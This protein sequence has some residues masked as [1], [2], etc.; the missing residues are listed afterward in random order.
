MAESYNTNIFTN[1]DKYSVVNG[2]YSYKG[3]LLASKISQKNGRSYKLIDAI[4]IDWNGAWVE[5]LSTYINNT[6][7][8]IYVLNAI[9]SN[10][11]IDDV[12]RMLD[13][14]RASL[15]EVQLSYVTYSYLS[16]ALSAYQTRLNAG[17]YI[18]IDSNN[19]ISTYD[20]VSTSLLN[21]TLMNYLSKAEF[22]QQIANYYT[23]AETDHKIQTEIEAAVDKI[24]DDADE[25]FD[26]LREVSDWILEQDK[27][28]PVT[29]DQVLEIQAKALMGEEHPDLYYKDPAKGTYKKVTDYNTIDTTGATIYYLRESMLDNVADIKERLS[30]LET[31]VGDKTTDNAGFVTYTGM[32]QQIE[33]LRLADIDIY[34]LAR[35][36]DNTANTALAIGTSAYTIANEAYVIAEES[37]A[38]G[39][40]GLTLAIDVDERVGM[41]SVPAH[42]AAM[43]P[44]AVKAEI[45]K[46]LT[47]GHTDT[48]LYIKRT[49][50]SGASYVEYYEPYNIISDTIIQG[51]GTLK[52]DDEKLA[53]IESGAFVLYEHKDDVIGTGLTKR[54][55]DVEERC[56]D[57]EE[58]IEEN[59]KL[60]YYLHSDD[61]DSE[62]VKL[63]I[64]P[65]TYD[66]N[67]SRTIHISH[68]TAAVDAY[69]GAILNNGLVD[70]YTLS[71]S[72]SYMTAWQLFPCSDP[73]HVL[74]SVEEK[75]ESI[76][77]E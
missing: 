23:K 67:K 59:S 27:Y 48:T 51:N 69:T 25:A 43:T 61:S 77:G 19:T 6:E 50:G 58:G 55:E 42:Y 38:I 31:T 39:Y 66:G 45:D 28:T 16:N 75:L 62:Y 21:T 13:A 29:L 33:H 9:N 3:I 26:T 46:Y 72:L 12:M 54:V 11:E 35:Q 5:T 60:L 2:E 53:E 34:N 36:A 32:R 73:E 68:D 14:L 1:V 4:D 24:I 71:D 70:A 56:A 41:P 57:L 44:D 40:E 49:S 10:D 52:Y 8:L 64:T 37:Y 18:R 7:D 65:E 47:N 30:T 63:N 20:L 76:T 22:L 17:A 15:R 74:P